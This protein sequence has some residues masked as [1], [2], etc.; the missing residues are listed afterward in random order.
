[1]QGPDLSEQS[2]RGSGIAQATSGGVATVNITQVYQAAVPAP[3][4][5]AILAAA[6]Q[7]LEQLP[8]DVVPAPAG[9]PPG[10]WMPLRRNA[11]FVGRDADLRRS[12]SALKAGGTAAVGQVRGGDRAG[13]HRQD[14]SWRASSPTA[15]ASISRAGCSGLACADPAAVP[16]EIAD[17]RR[18]GD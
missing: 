13:R 7:R 15:T 3:I 4:E 16:A 8:L 10:S 17:L 12:G 18:R 11:L 2:A 1:M 9:L 6:V 14:A 5:P